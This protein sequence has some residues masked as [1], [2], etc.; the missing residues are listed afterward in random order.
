MAVAFLTI[1]GWAQSPQKMSYQCVVRN[2][3]GALVAS[4]PVGLKIS[5]L[6]GS[7]TGT[8]VFSE[9]FSPNPQTNPN[10]LVT[11]EIG[12]GTATVGTF[13]SIDWASGPFFLKTETDPAGGTNYTITGTSQLLSVPYA[14]Y[15]K[16]AAN[17]FS[18]NYNDLTNKPVLFD[19]TWLSLTGKPV[20][21]DG[22][23]AS[24]TGKPVLFDGTWAS[25]TGKPSFAA[26]ATSGSY[27]DLLNRPTLF[28]GS[29]ND[30]TNKP[31]LFDGTWNSLTG[32]PAGFADGIDNVD[33]ADNSISNEIQALS[34]SGTVLTL[35][36]GGGSVTLPSSGGGD[37]WGTQTVVTNTTLTGAG[38][39]ASPLAVAN[40][41]ITPLWS[42][43]QSIPAGFADGTDNIDD[44]DNSITN[45]IQTLNL[46]GTTLSLSGGG[47]SVTLPSS[48]GGDNWGTQ[49]VVTNTTLTGAGTTASPLAVANTVITPSW[50]HIQSIPAGFAD[51]TDNVD[52]ADNSITNEIQTLSL[53]GSTLALSN[54][55]GSVTLP[56]DN[57]G[58]Q[59]VMTN[60]TLTGNGTT[61]TP[62]RI[63]QQSATSG[64]VLK[65]NGTS[66]SWQ[67]AD[68]AIGSGLTLP[69]SGS[70]I[71]EL[72]HGVFEVTDNRTDGSGEITSAVYGISKSV[73]GSGVL[74]RA[75]AAS[76]GA[77]GVFGMTS[78]PSGSGVWG[79]GNVYG[80][81]GVSTS[82][83]I[84]Q[85]YGIYGYVMS[86]E[87]RGVY[88]NAPKYG[89]YGTSTGSQGRAVVG[90]ATGNSSIGVKGVAINTNSTGV[91]GEGANQGV[92][93]VSALATGKGLYGFASSSTG[94]NAGVYGETTSDA[95]YGVYGQ[96][97][98]YGIY[99]NATTTTADSAFGVYGKSRSYG[100]IGISTGSSGDTYPRYGVYG[101]CQSVGHAG[102]LGKGPA[103]GVRGYATSTYSYASG[104]SGTSFS[105][106]RGIGVYGYAYETTGDNYGIYGQA[107]SATGTG[108][109]GESPKFGVYGT[110]TGNQGRAVVGEA[111]GTASI[112]V[113]G[114]ATNT[115]STGVMGEGANYDFYA[116]GPG[117]DYGT[118]SS[119]R[120]K[121]NIVS[122]P[123]PLGKL[124]EIR[125]VFFDWDNDHG[126]KHDVGVIAEEV[127]RVLPE[128]VVYEENGI[129]AIGLDYS[130]LT[131]LLLEAIKEQQRQLESQQKEIDE[132]KVLV[133]NLT[134]S[135]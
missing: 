15:A 29:Y 85:T 91:W 71:A 75:D 1:S 109:Y 113:R 36:N 121:E 82:T 87:G 133:R 129:D 59:A 11:V 30:L 23:W 105:P 65:W 53:A 39:T 81:I 135:K 68:D 55:G 72:Q 46:S 99:A 49:T 5:I 32:K 124:K 111:T 33:D 21:F 34:I 52:D 38:T 47:G 108:V 123:E 48:G 126:G 128:I 100:V 9:T 43:I 58:T 84:A 74:G 119:I 24:L 41:V 114:I 130:K 88:G 104:V 117:V 79:S 131:P 56:G 134:A 20:L 96:S 10:G 54:G 78:S 62:L 106:N 26:V 92:Y 116:N 16:S 12:G 4:Q 31:V 98:R 19:G 13:T 45:E 122:I 37:N 14:L 66:S 3:S 17:G 112:G 8:V 102:V 120:W 110:S 60:A 101:E 35:S 83:S 25:L 73:N 2:T 7:A 86:S 42:H 125:G 6:K 27:N 63:A 50:S 107:K 44:A 93:G 40:T 18:G 103:T 61:A 69:W 94:Q 77:I 80:V 51:G 95:G 64:Q 118:S 76:G 22:T 67:P 132:L 70:A 57:W 127:G 90:D 89:V 97:P 28:S 115:S